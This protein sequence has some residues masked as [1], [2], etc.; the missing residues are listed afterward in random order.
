MASLLAHRRKSFPA[1]SNSYKAATRCS[2][3]FEWV[4]DGT[5]G[6]LVK[7]RRS[8]AQ[9]GVPRMT[10][11]RGSL[12]RPLHLVRARQ[13]SPNLIFL[14]ALG[15]RPAPADPSHPLPPAAAA[16]PPHPPLSAKRQTP[17][18]PCAPARRTAPAVLRKP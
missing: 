17:P 11:A 10:S 18:A 3:H 9:R 7:C 5:I 1:Q 8:G 14:S 16:Q 6:A 2:Q 13:P 12:G 4:T 15:P